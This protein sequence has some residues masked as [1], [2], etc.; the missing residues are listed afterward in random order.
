MKNNN[1]VDKI[2]TALK[3]RQLRKEQ[4]LRFN[5]Q[6]SQSNCKFVNHGGDIITS[7]KNTNISD[8]FLIIAGIFLVP[9]VIGIF[10][11]YSVF[12]KK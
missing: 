10:I 9:A 5:Q 11:L 8:I 3:I 7:I 4:I 1:Q 12:S 2:N 6:D